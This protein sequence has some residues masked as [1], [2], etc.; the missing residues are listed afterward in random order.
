MSEMF[1]QQKKTFLGGCTYIIIVFHY[2]ITIII[3]I[4]AKK[5]NRIALGLVLDLYPYKIY[6]GSDWMVTLP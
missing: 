4:V 2:L 6:Q 1:K 5:Q 3:L